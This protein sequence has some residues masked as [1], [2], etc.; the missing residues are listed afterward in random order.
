MPS[1]TLSYFGFTTTAHSLKIAFSSAVCC[2]TSRTPEATDQP[3]PAISKVF[4][5]LANTTV[6]T[7]FREP[8]TA[9][10]T[11]QKNEGWIF[12]NIQPESNG[13]FSRNGDLILKRQQNTLCYGG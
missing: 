7:P 3:I 10:A 13:E 2:K 5:S 1:P 11:E 8:Q 6:K 12:L 4:H 9:K